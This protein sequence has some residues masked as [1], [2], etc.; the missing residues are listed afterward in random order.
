MSLDN[1]KIISFVSRMINFVTKD[2]MKILSKNNK[3]LYFAAL[4]EKFAYYH[5]NCPGLF[6]MIA[7]DPD[8]FDMLRLQQMLVMKTKVEQQNI[9]YENASKKIGQD[10]FDEFVEPMVNKLDQK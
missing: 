7:D 6:N 8:D 10:Y 2:E 4:D 5:E 9:S 3:R 1:D